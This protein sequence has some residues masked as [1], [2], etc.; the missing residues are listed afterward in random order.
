MR[1]ITSSRAAPASARRGKRA[2]RARP[3]AAKPFTTFNFRTKRGC[4]RV[5]VRPKVTLFARGRVE[6][7]RHR[8]GFGGRRRGEGGTEG[9]GRPVSRLAVTRSVMGDRRRKN[10]RARQ[11]AVCKSESSF[12]GKYRRIHH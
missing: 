5:V 7:G 8:C 6:R 12:F 2:A 11:F 1:R 4:S 10:A 3:N 9:S